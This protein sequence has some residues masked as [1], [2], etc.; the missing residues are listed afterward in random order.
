M[1]L[2][3]SRIPTCRLPKFTRTANKSDVF[4]QYS[5]SLPTVLHALHSVQET[6][7][8]AD[9]TLS[10][11]LRQLRP[12]LRRPASGNSHLRPLSQFA[13]LLHSRFPR[14]SYTTK[15]GI[16]QPSLPLRSLQ[17]RRVSDSTSAPSSAVAHSPDH[18]IDTQSPPEKPPAYEI[19][20]TCK[21]CGHRS[22]HT[23]SKLGYHKGTVLITCPDCSNRHVIS[24]HLKV[25][26]QGFYEVEAK[27][28]RSK[29]T[30]TDEWH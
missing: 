11:I 24:D 5:P 1:F 23:I 9:Q 30:N 21:P 13:P 4:S 2:D 3:A 25:R 29:A 18:P 15:R 19:T 14:P 16:P 22:T 17:T 27:L 10:S 26:F 7:M 8:K 28:T 20:F 12:S 6:M